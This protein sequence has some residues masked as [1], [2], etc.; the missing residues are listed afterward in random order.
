MPDPQLMILVVDVEC[1]ECGVH[2]T[3]T[4]PGNVAGPGGQVHRIS[5][6]EHVGV[7]RYQ[8]SEWV[9]TELFMSDWLQGATPVRSE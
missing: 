6:D 2:L 9:A 1:M 7:A 8:L 4:V 5:C 3:L